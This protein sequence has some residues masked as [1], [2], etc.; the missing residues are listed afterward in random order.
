MGAFPPARILVPVDFSDLSVI[1]WKQAFALGARF[2]AQVEAVHVA[3]FVRARN[4][5]PR[6]LSPRERRELTAA[7]ASTY[8]GAAALHV[9]EGDVLLGVLRTAR[10]IA[11][12]LIVMGTGGRTGL[13]R[14]MLPSLTEDLIR[15]SRVPV[16]AIH[17]AAPAPAPRSILAPVNLKPYSFEG[18]AAAERLARALGA[19]VTALFVDETGSRALARKR[20]EY[21]VSQLRSPVKIAVAVA[22]GEPV[23]TI[24][25]H[26]AKHD[27]VV[28]TVH[29][30][31]AF[32]DAVL[33]STA[34]QVLR[35]AVL[36]VMA[37]PPGL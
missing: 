25:S 7:L 27:L 4:T 8:P 35:R 24:L 5:M 16:L 31:G 2:G 6:D 3:K 13:K 21:A 20:L 34:Q 26:A 15:S 11:A 19:R 32:H 14:L 9:V 37:V 10:T 18:L 22:A 29:R 23:E 33:G 12:G 36:P 30:K 1:A 28:M 17:G